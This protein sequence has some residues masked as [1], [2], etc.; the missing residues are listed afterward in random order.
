VSTIVK[1][2]LSAHKCSQESLTMRVMILYK[3]MCVN[4]GVLMLTTGFNDMYPLDH[5]NLAHRL[6]GSDPMI[7]EH[8]RATQD[9]WP[10]EAD[11][12]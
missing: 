12:N 10:K 9:N 11:D 6:M 8:R 3:P 5:S 1:R 7:I 2:V 4:S